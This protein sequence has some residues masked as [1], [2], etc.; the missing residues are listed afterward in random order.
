MVYLD[1]LTFK[2]LAF[3]S[4][5]YRSIVAV[6]REKPVGKAHVHH[7]QSTPGSRTHKNTSAGVVH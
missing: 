7:S 3:F 6:K 1:L 5:T 2:S 4:L